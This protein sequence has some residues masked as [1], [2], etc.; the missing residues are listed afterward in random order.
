MPAIYRF[1]L[2]LFL[3]KLNFFSLPAF[4][5]N[6]NSSSQMDGA[7]IQQHRISGM[8]G[9]NQTRTSIP[10]AVGYAGILV[11]GSADHI[12]ATLMVR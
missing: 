7:I 11:I 4:A 3:T 8:N 2:T 6:P 1:I 9:I 10:L 5:G 12:P